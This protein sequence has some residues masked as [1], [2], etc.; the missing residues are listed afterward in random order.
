MKV[1]AYQFSGVLIAT[2]ILSGCGPGSSPA[3][4][5]AARALDTPSR[6][7]SWMRPEAEGENLLY[8]T[9]SWTTGKV[10]VFSYPM[11]KHV[12]TLTGFYLPSGE[13][14]DKRGDVWLLNLSPAEVIEYAHGGTSPIATLNDPTKEGVSC[15][16]DPTSGDLAVASAH[17]AEVEI[18]KHATGTPTIYSD[19][20]VPSFDACTYDDHGNLFIVSSGASH[21]LAELPSGGNSILAIAFPAFSLG[22]IQW[23]GHNLAMSIFGGSRGPAKIL[24]VQVVGASARIV[25]KTY[26]YANRDKQ[27]GGVQFWI[28]GNRIVM[29]S[30]ARITDTVIGVWSYPFGGDPVNRLHAWHSYFLSG[31]TVSP[32]R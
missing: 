25:G 10:Y 2:S 32:K 12:G 23:D 29:P 21:P 15:S 8:V 18:Y 4:M 19:P 22:N 6:S 27:V 11:G 14:V 5:P 16:V 28:A 24:R 9:D 7:G 20:D 3:I 17:P 31:V 13:C 26:L 30:Q 1:S